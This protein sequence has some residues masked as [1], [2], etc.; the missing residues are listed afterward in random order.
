MRQYHGTELKSQLLTELLSANGLCVGVETEQD[1]LVD[2]WVLVLSPGTFLDFGIGGSDD[3]LDL[4]AVDETS[5]IRISDFG[6]RQ[7]STT[8]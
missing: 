5:D 7:A 4:S 8:S 2:Q 1:T 6:R 3:R